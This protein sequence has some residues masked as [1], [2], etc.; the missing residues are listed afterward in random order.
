MS[1][2]PAP[3]QPWT[4][5]IP[6]QADGYDVAFPQF[7]V[8]LS[9]G[10]QVTGT[11]LLANESLASQGVT[12]VTEAQYKLGLAAEDWMY[13][14][15]AQETP[16]VVAAQQAL[17][18]AKANL[19]A[20]TVTLQAAVTAAQAVYDPLATS[21]NEDHGLLADY[22]VWATNLRNLWLASVSTVP[23]DITSP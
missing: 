8:T 18:Q 11:P 13:N 16:A 15:V 5:K 17:V 10:T 4:G 22:T 9:D 20:A 1:T 6:M 12:Q 21:Y 19:A 7:T 3:L 2:T 14:I 23:I